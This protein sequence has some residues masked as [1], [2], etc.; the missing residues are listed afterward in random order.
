MSREHSGPWPHQVPQNWVLTLHAWS[1]ARSPCLCQ[2]WGGVETSLSTFMRTF[3]LSVLSW[4]AS[5]GSLWLMRPGNWHSHVSY[6]I[7]PPSHTS[8]LCVTTGNGTSA[9][10]PHYGSLFIPAPWSFPSLLL[11]STGT[12][13][14]LIFKA[15]L[16]INTG[17]GGGS[18]VSSMYH[19]GWKSFSAN[20]WKRWVSNLGI[21]S[22]KPGVIFKNM[23]LPAHVNKAERLS[24]S[25]F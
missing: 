14:S 3:W 5:P 17:V 6:K 9:L 20:K 8:A 10:L 4:E 23:F 11:I 24:Q 19:L 18:H 15:F 1:R 21:L 25:E 16:Y 22:L 12:V 13:N 2:T 7:F